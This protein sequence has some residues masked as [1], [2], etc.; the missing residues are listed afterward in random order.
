MTP[1]AR[2]TFTNVVTFNGINSRKK[3]PGAHRHS[4]SATR[5]TPVVLVLIGHAVHVTLPSAGLYLAR[6]HGRH[7]KEELVYP[8]SHAHSSTLDA[9]AGFSTREFAGQAAHDSDV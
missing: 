6:A 1:H 5:A 7:A 4:S 9:L 2:A 3:K 8:A